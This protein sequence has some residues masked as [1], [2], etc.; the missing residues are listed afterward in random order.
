MPRFLLHPSMCVHCT[1]SIYWVHSGV[2]ASTSRRCAVSLGS[3]YGA[4]CRVTVCRLSCTSALILSINNNPLHCRPKPHLLITI[5]HLSDAP[6]PSFACPLQPI[7][8]PSSLPAG[9]VI[10][11]TS[12]LCLPL[13]LTPA[14]LAFSSEIWCS[15]QRDPLSLSLVSHTLSCSSSRI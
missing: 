1:V 6:P 3:D 15:I 8:P 4:W 12:A 14:W 5:C 2:D 10:L 13:P 11:Y 7:S 9:P